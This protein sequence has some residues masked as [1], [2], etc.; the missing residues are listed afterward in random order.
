[1]MKKRAPLSMS[2]PASCFT[3]G[4]STDRRP[5]SSSTTINSIWRTS[6]ERL[7]QDFRKD[8]GNVRSSKHDV[9]SLKTGTT[10]RRLLSKKIVIYRGGDKKTKGR[11]VWTPCPIP[12]KS[13]QDLK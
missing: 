10:K 9:K 3:W 6:M 5:D 2:R 8:T 11:G 1:M 13:L 12:Q 7:I 4:S